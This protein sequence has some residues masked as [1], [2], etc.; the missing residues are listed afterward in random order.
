M[1]SLNSFFFPFNLVSTL[2]STKPRQQSKKD[3]PKTGSIPAR[4]S[5]L[6][7]KR[8]THS[9]ILLENMLSTLQVSPKQ[10]K[11][12][13]SVERTPLVSRS[14]QVHKITKQADHGFVQPKDLL[15]TNQALGLLRKGDALIPEDVYSPLK[16]HDA[17]GLRESMG[18]TFINRSSYNQTFGDVTLDPNATSFIIRENS[19]D[20]RSFV[21]ESRTLRKETKKEPAKV[22]PLVQ[23]TKNVEQKGIDIPNWLQESNVQQY[24]YN[25]I[26]ALKRKLSAA[27]EESKSPITP[28]V[29]E[30]FE[31]QD[32]YHKM[33]FVNDKREYESCS[34]TEVVTNSDQ[35]RLLN[36]TP[37]VKKPEPLETVRSGQKRGRGRKISF[38]FDV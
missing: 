36:K 32:K 16:I 29:K 21:N 19:Q 12:P 23:E 27:I 34:F 35:E 17:T 3:S 8:M 30:E 13:T 7:D 26:T 1:T 37:K 2:D 6:T 10:A 15:K 9:D 38:C 22:S 33:A 25:F 4:K 20:E 28:L 18:Q 11:E 5:P 14:D 31:K 24:P